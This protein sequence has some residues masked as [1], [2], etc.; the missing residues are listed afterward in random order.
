MHAPA[1]L[2]GQNT[3]GIEACIQEIN[4]YFQHSSAMQVSQRKKLKWCV[5]AVDGG[6]NEY[7]LMLA[8]LVHNHF[9]TWYV[10]ILEVSLYIFQTLSKAQKTLDKLFAECHLDKEDSVNYTS[11]NDFFVVCHLVLGKK[12]RCERDFVEWLLAWHLTKKALMGPFA[13]PFAESAGGLC[14]ASVGLTLDKEGSNGALCRSLCRVLGIQHST[15]K[16]YRFPSM[17]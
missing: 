14:W 4:M 17:H 5:C 3:R 11:S 7:D 12:N 16:L 2:S 10:I 1:S 6:S 13:N 15:K 9:Y 8:L